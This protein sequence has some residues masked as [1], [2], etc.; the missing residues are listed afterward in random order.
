M[1]KW[2]I[3]Y[4]ERRRTTMIKQRVEQF[5]LSKYSVALFTTQQK[6]RV[7]MWCMILATV[8]VVVSAVT[9]T[10]ISPQV[11]EVRY[12]ASMSTIVTGLIACLVLLKKGFY[13]LASNMG[14]IMPMFLVTFQGLIISSTAGKYIYLQ[15]LLMFVVMAALFSNIRMTFIIT[16]LLIVCGFTI[17][18]TSGGLIAESSVK[19]V[20]TH[21]VL[22][23][24]FIAIL[25]FFILR[26]QRA[27]MDETEKKNENLREQFD[28][29]NEIIGTCSTVSSHLSNSMESLT[30]S[31]GTF[32]GNAQTQAAS[33]EE[34]TSTIEQVSANTEASYRFTK[35]LSEQ[36]NSL[37]DNIREMFTIV[38]QSGDRMTQ[39]IAYKEDLDEEIND[40]KKL[41]SVCQE[42]MGG[43]LES[44]K[45][46]YEATT[47]INDVSDQINLL[48]LN[49]SIEA[50]RAGEHGKGFAVVAEEIGKLAEKTQVNAKEITKLVEQTDDR[51]ALTSESLA[52]V[53]EGSDSIMK[54]SSDFGTLVTE[55]HGLSQK[56]LT[57]NQDVQASAQAVLKGSEDVNV[58][59]EELKTAIDEITNSISVINS[60]TQQLA[61]GSDDLKDVADSVMTS[62]EELVDVLKQ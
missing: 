21:F 41:I 32:S 48:S 56:D 45:H 5:F 20:N 27:S 33:I 9:T 36:I 25:C 47:L 42:A 53:D 61:S 26:I 57:L 1:L 11:V 3:D 6:A 18:N 19:S 2:S 52:K 7:F 13:K 55:V 59:L 28:R 22:V 35:M 17:V 40:T 58:A 14:I 31:A 39:A 50:A 30:V 16:A 46:V 4:K 60:S 12:F 51:L 44:G 23:T 49:A 8:L 43:A 10:I 15:Y 24:S 34:I 29:I 62:T 38:T 37:L 54:L